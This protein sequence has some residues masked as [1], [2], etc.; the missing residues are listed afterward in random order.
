[1]DS[2]RR[3]AGKDRTHILDSVEIRSLLPQAADQ[4]VEFVQST[5]TKRL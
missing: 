5:S 4:A 3:F 2:D 1:M